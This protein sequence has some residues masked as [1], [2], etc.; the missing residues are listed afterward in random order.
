MKIG[1]VTQPLQLNYGGLLQNYALQEVLRRLGHEPC[2]LNWTWP[3]TYFQDHEFRR[4]LSN[5]KTRIMTKMHLG[6]GRQLVKYKPSDTEYTVIAQNTDRFIREHIVKTRTI[7]SE[8]GFREVFE[9]GNYYALISGSDQVWRPKYSAPFLKEMFLDFAKDKKVVRLAYAASFGMDEWE[10]SPKMTE[11][12]S[13]LAKKYDAI[14][15]REDSGIALCCEHLGVTAAHV[16]DPTLLLRKEDY[17]NL[18]KEAGETASPGSLFYYILDPSVAKTSFVERVADEMNLHPFKVMPRYPRSEWTKPR[19]KHH[20]DDCVYP[21]L[22]QWLRGFM[23]AEMTVVDSF[24]GMV[25]SILFNKPFW[26][27]GNKSRGLSRFTSLL[28]LLGL[29]NRLLDISE[30]KIVEVSTPIDWKQVNVWLDRLRQQSQDWLL[31]S[32]QK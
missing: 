18:V 22:T 32:L 9:A 8:D 7:T 16:L 24:H 26:V 10:F 27:I 15:V 11:K 3:H 19:I 29:E 6:A 2:T 14:S 4:L 13:D 21:S 17:V 20:I 1:I 23:D 12:C 31:K 30:L 28:T 25:F 5:V